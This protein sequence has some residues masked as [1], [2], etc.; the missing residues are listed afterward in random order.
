MDY[1][2]ELSRINTKEA[3]S[4]I[5]HLKNIYFDCGNVSDFWNETEI[6][7]WLSDESDYCIGAYYNNEIIGFCLTHY[8]AQVNKVHLENI[9]VV[10]NYRRKG[11][12]KKM[13][14]EVFGFYNKLGKR[15][16][17]IGLVNTNNDNAVC[18]LKNMDFIIGEKM[19]WVQKNPKGI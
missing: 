14:K 4:I 2:I 11:I 10:E 6:K 7:N 1:V 18:M 17:Y 13:L 12:A 16:R 5:T 19:F 9:F 8:H 3:L 15:I